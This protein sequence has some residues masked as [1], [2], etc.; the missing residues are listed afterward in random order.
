[1]FSRHLIKM[2]IGLIGMGLVGIICLFL[3]DMYQKQT[4]TKVPTTEVLP[5]PGSANSSQ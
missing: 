5:G 4:N 3:I 2:L 1:M